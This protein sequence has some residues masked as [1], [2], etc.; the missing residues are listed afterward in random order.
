MVN[1]PSLA[2]WLCSP[3]SRSSCPL[4][5]PRPRSAHGSLLSLLRPAAAV[6]PVAADVFE[7]ASL[8]LGGQS[9]HEGEREHGQHSEDG[10]GP[11]SA[12]SAERVEE[13]DADYDVRC[14]VRGQHGRTALR[15]EPGG[16]AFGSVGPDNSAITEV[17]SHG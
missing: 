5:A 3:V 11:C 17:E 8:R 12:Q 7:L 13:Y 1:L 15:A 9:V 2:S 6:V 10:E 14:Q 4:R 16:K